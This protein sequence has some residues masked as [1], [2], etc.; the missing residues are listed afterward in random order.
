VAWVRYRSDG[1]FEGPI[2]DTDARMC[3][4]RRSFWTPLYAAPLAQ[5]AEQDR[6]DAERY[7]WLRVQDDDDFCFAVV[8]N[9]HFDLYESPEELDAAIDAAKGA[10]K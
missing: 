9:A 8:K 7:R 5:S 3:D 10:S 4:T 1:G 2:M 6:I